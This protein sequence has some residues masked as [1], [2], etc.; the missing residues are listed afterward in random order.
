[1]RRRGVVSGSDGEAAC[2]QPPHTEPVRKRES[3]HDARDAWPTLSGAQMWGGRSVRG[4]P[5]EAT[6]RTCEGPQGKMSAALVRRSC[7]TV[8]LPATVA[9]RVDAGGAR[10]D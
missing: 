6:A 8:P 2:A 5:G 7:V 1:M 10:G 9:L 3:E 4:E